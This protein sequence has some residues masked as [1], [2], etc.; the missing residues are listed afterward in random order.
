MLPSIYVKLT[1]SDNEYLAYP[2]FGLL[3]VLELGSNGS[4]ICANFRPLHNGKLS[5]YGQVK[6][7]VFE[8]SPAIAQSG[9]SAVADLVQRQRAGDDSRNYPHTVI[10]DGTTDILDVT[11]NR[12]QAEWFCSVH[13]L[14]IK[15]YRHTVGTNHVT[16]TVYPTIGTKALAAIYSILC[17]DEAS[18]DEELVAHFQ[19]F[20]LT[21]S[22]AREQVAR[23]AAPTR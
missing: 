10:I 11:A 5:G 9:S 19:T 20:G 17:N 7:P 2:A 8:Y 14:R 18:T 13:G 22:Q 16:A 23:R 1:A 12:D 3:E 6:N 15:E 4:I 21:A